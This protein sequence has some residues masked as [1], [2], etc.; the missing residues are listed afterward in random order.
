MILVDEAESTSNN[1]S[2]SESRE[3]RE[4]ERCETIGGYRESFGVDT[5][6]NGEGARLDSHNSDAALSFD[7]LGRS[8]INDDRGGI[9]LCPRGISAGHNWK[10]MNERAKTLIPMPS[11]QL[12]PGYFPSPLL[13]SFAFMLSFHKIA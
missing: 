12:F 10:K 1:A 8:A 3:R 11:K 13:F 5:D 4:E 7:G 9:I 2:R 6:G